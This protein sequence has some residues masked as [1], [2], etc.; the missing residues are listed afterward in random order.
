[1]GS[2]TMSAMLLIALLGILASC[3]GA[4]LS[5]QPQLKRYFSSDL[6]G[7]HIDSSFKGFKDFRDSR[8]ARIHIKFDDVKKF[9]KSSPLKKIDVDIELTA[10]DGGA[11]NI[12]VN[13]L[14][15]H[16]GDGEETGKVIFDAAELNSEL[17][18][19]IETKA[20]HFEGEPTIP[21]K[22][23]NLNIM[24][25][26]D[27]KNQLK[28]I[29]GYPI[30]KDH[31]E[32]RLTKVSD[33][34]LKI[35]LFMREILMYEIDYKMNCSTACLRGNRLKVADLVGHIPDEKITGKLYRYP[36]YRFKPEYHFKEKFELLLK[37]RNER[38]LEIEFEFY[39]DSPWFRKSFL[40]PGP[41]DKTL[42]LLLLGF[43]F[44]FE[45]YMNGDLELRMDLALNQQ[46]NHDLRFEFKRNGKSIFLHQTSI[47]FDIPFSSEINLETIMKLDENSKLYQ[48]LDANYPYGT[49]KTRKMKLNLSKFQLDFQL[50]KD[51][52]KVVD[53]AG[54]TR[55]WPF[56]FKLKAPNFFKRWGI[57]VP[58]PSLEVT[59]DYKNGNTII[60]D[61][62]ILNG[63]HFEAQLTGQ[64]EG[65]RNVLILLENGDQLIFKVD[66]A[67]VMI[68]DKHDLI[69][70]YQLKK[71]LG[72]LNPLKVTMETISAFNLL[73]IKQGVQ[74]ELL[75]SDKNRVIYTLTE[76]KLEVNVT[77]NYNLLFMKCHWE[78]KLPKTIQEAKSFLLK[79]KL[80]VAISDTIENTEH[81]LDFNWNFQTP[82]HGKL[83]M[84]MEG[85]D[86]RLK[87]SPVAMDY[88]LTRKLEWGK[89]EQKI[90]LKYSGEYSGLW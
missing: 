81:K 56:K 42:P 23:S 49:F 48:W 84:S 51:R 80:M 78:G 89:E 70:L 40:V 59:A 79:N 57:E 5:G 9:Y 83:G 31:I 10:G 21:V 75:G 8:Q 47:D 46:D 25:D 41:K 82:E 3:Q 13:Y 87:G 55:S 20:E 45:D 63:I 72:K 61:A 86:P 38:W 28:I 39:F 76:D 35:E 19:R 11:L 67:R 68:N 26:V 88:S 65:D 58:S 18:F 66:L 34:I 27:M 33:D 73:E 71:V 22:I 54:D 32:L 85:P 30:K 37:K 64:A 4:S 62:N 90:K 14:L 60:V 16:D 74:V 2:Q 29:Y 50:E 15:I 6:F 43:D 52:V 44:R 77:Q 24:L 53:L 7:V 12:A 69:L 36:E 17:K 1:M